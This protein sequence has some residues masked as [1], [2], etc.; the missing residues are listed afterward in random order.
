MVVDA[1]SIEANVLFTTSGALVDCVDKKM[2]VILRDGKKLIGVMRS[3]DQFANLVFQD[4][5]ERVFVDEKF[6]DVPRGIFLIRGENVVMLGEVDLDADPPPLLTPIHPEQI[7]A[8]TEAQRQESESRKL[9]DQRKAKI[10][11]AQKG[12]CEE[13]AEGD[14]Y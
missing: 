7:P 14:H 11:K 6:V 2:M 12:F 3:Y 10:M 9:R 8:I 13:G 1:S 4:T 5:V